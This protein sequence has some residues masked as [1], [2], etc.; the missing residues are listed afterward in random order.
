MMRQDTL[1]F[2][3]PIF[4]SEAVQ[5]YESN[6]AKKRRDRVYT[7]ENSLMT[8]VV[9]ALHADRSLQNSVRI[10]QEVF[11]R[12]REGVLAMALEQQRALKEAI[13][14]GGK[15]KRGRPRTGKV[16]IPISKI[17]DISS[18]TAAFSKARERIDVALIEHAYKASA[19]FSTLESSSRWHGRL[20]YNTDG[21][22]FQMQ[23]TQEIPEKYRVQ[24]SS[25]GLTQ[26]YP[27]GLLQVLTQHGSGLLAAYQ[28]AGRDESELDVLARMMP[29]IPRN[30]LLLADDL[31]NCYAM[32]HLL[33]QHGVDII[34]PDKKQRKYRVVK[35][36]ANGDEIIEIAKPSGVRRL[37]KGQQLPPT[38]K[39]RRVTYADPVNAENQWVLL[40]T[41]LDAGIEKTDIVCR[42]SSRWDVEISIREIKTLMGINI[43]RAKSEQMA[44]R[45]IG[46]ALL[47]YNLVRRIIAQSTAETPFSPETGLFEKLYSSHTTALV[48]R[49]GRVYCRWSPGRPAAYSDETESMLDSVQTRQTLSSKNKSRKICE[50]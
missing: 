18:N 33:M 29:Q 2:I 50:V 4:P 30:S 8:M 35:T 48:D 6:A 27:Q 31:Y 39:L 14:T 34:V 43:V 15:R 23:D 19:D 11:N 12:H 42:Y 45:E 10:F 40:T 26:G 3:A 28:V 20:V 38:L 47:A 24:R 36:L 17:K 41:I 25:N 21:T 1:Q 7:T 13:D 22:Y 9:T 37:V 5:E 16:R 32:F 44:F 46:V 49:K